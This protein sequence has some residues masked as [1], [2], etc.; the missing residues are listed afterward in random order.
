MRSKS[1]ADR[2]QNNSRRRSPL[3]QGAEARLPRSA[4][5]AQVQAL[6]RL[7]NSVQE[8]RTAHQLSYR[9]AIRMLFP[10][11]DFREAKDKVAERTAYGHVGE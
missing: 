6:L 4:G 3:R 2:R 11:V 1:A 10:P 7:R 5:P 9:R 8:S